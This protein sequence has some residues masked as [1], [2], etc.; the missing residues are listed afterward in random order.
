MK[1]VELVIKPVTRVA[2]PYPDIQQI[3]GKDIVL[4][5]IPLERHDLPQTTQDADQ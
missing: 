1:K 4:D 2:E 3:W 5:N